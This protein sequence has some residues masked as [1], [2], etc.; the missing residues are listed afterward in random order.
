MYVMLA[1]AGSPD[2]LFG[3]PAAAATVAS[4]SLAFAEYED[5]AASKFRRRR[6]EIY[7]TRD[8]AVVKSVQ[9]QKANWPARKLHGMR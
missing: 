5:A 6:R 2:K 9:Q 3:R 7:L 4:C 1:A 8:L